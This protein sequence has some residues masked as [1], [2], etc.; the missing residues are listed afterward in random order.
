MDGKLLPFHF[1]NKRTDRSRIKF[2]KPDS[3]GKLPEFLDKNKF[4]IVHAGLL[5]GARNPNGAI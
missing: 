3:S 4:N 2:V 1:D 5:M